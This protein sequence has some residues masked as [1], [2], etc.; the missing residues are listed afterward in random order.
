MSSIVVV[1]GPVRGLTHR[2]E[3][4]VTVIGRD[5]QCHLYVA[6]DHISRRHLEIRFDAAE[7]SYVAVD[8]G[9]TNGTVI[10]DQR[11]TESRLRDGVVMTIGDSK[12]L[13]ADRDFPDRESA[14]AYA[15]ESDERPEETV[16]TNRKAIDDSWSNA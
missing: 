11:I 3:G 2:L 7:Q 6:D 15:R 16:R 10:G 5:E 12:L 4:P 1:S 8:L 14:M 13:F 9:S